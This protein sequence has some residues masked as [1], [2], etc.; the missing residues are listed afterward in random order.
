MN[1]S[2]LGVLCV[3]GD[4]RLLT[5]RAAEIAELETAKD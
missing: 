4:E 5:R 3:L 2:V 1:R